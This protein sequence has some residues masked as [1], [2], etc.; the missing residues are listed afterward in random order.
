MVLRDM[1]LQ[2]G[3]KKFGKVTA[4]AMREINA[5]Q[6]EQR[7]KVLADRILDVDSWKD[8]LK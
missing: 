4:K 6:D 2:Q 1:I 5:I 3:K 7:L 8:L